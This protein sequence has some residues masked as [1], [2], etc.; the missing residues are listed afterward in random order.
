MNAAPSTA[1]DWWA[2]VPGW[3]DRELTSE[4]GL[5]LEVIRAAVTRM[6]ARG[7]AVP[8]ELLKLHLSLG[9]CRELM[10]SFNR[11]TKPEEWKVQDGFL[12]FLEE[13]QGVCQ[14]LVDASE[15]VW[16]L[17]NE[18]RY[19][20]ELT[21]NDFLAVVVPYQLA[22]GGWS[23]AADM[24]LPLT[25]AADMQERLLRELDWPLLAQHN[26]L[27][28]HSQGASMLWWLDPVSGN[29]IQHL[30]MSCLRQSDLENLCVRF[31]FVD[32]D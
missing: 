12:M 8:P 15:R 20:E 10:D 21:L 17:V 7:F 3:L 23:Y 18:E 4:D 14:W 24:V 29:T 5:P 16:M 28:I 19:P 31:G 25:E 11:F 30:F 13:N 1:F 27:T 9:A 22:Q 2:L 26:G 6:A 32:L